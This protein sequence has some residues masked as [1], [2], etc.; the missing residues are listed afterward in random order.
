LSLPACYC[1]RV[2]LSY[3]FWCFYYDFKS[4]S[5]LD[6]YF[7]Q[8]PLPN[9]IYLYNISQLI[10][11]SRQSSWLNHDFLDIELLLT[12]K[13]KFEDIKQEIKSC[14]STKDKTPHKTRSIEQQHEYHLNG[15]ELRCS[16]S[17]CSSCSSSGTLRTSLET[18]FPSPFGSE[19]CS[20]LDWY[21]SQ[22]PLPNM[23]YLYNISQ[24]IRRSRQSSWLNHDFQY[25]EHWLN[26]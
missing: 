14:N 22:I 11:R 2:V 23:I 4:C 12:K 20:S 21:F 13:L 26:K 25:L 3:I 18:K 24:L 7:S 10:R 17:A 1:I 9:M 19:S 15:C 5:S 16:S 6:W 8:I